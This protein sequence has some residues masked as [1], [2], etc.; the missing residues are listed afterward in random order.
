GPHAL[1]TR[2]YAADFEEVK[3]FGRATGSSRTQEQTDA[4]NYRGR[5]NAPPTMPSLLRSV[6]SGQGGSLADHARM[7]ARAYTNGADALIVTWRDKARYGFWRPVTA[8]HEAPKH[9]Q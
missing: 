3:A 7:L 6:A 1:H 8:I 5:G 9:G 2:A 4:A